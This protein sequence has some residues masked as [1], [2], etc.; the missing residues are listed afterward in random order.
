MAMRSTDPRLPVRFAM[1]ACAFFFLA[2]QAFLPLLG[3]QNDEAI[4][5]CAFWQP[6]GGYM[7]RLGHSHLPLML[8]SY[9]GTL[10]AWIYRPIFAVFPPGVWSLREPAVLFGV[11]SLW[12]FFL[13]LRRIAGARAAVI[14][15]G[16]LAVDALYLL[17]VSF[18]WGPVAL[19]HLLFVG[20]MLLLMRFYQEGSVRSL[21]W[22]FFLLG[23]AMWDK[24]LA[25]WMLSGMGVA[26]A[27]IFPKQIWRVA[28]PRRAAV[29]A[30]CFSLGALPLIV[31]DVNN[32]F[33]TFRGHRYS[34]GDIAG[35]ARMLMNTANGSALFGWLADEDWQTA[36]PH[37]PANALQKVS[38][39][40]SDWAGEPR[41][42]LL[43]YAFALALL[44]TPLARGG[45][46]RAILFVLIAMAVQWVQMAITVD[47]GGSVHHT[48]LLWPLPE[49]AIAVSFAAASRRLGRA[50]IPAAAGILAVTMAAGALQIN[51]YYRLA[52][53]NGGAQNW[54]DAIFPLSDAMKG[55]HAT[56]VYSV[57]WGILDS[58][59]L[60]D[61]GRLRQEA[62]FDA[63]PPDQGTP[64]MPRIAAAVGKPDDVFIAHCQGFEFFEGRNEKLLKVAEA[65]GFRRETI[66]VIRDS[67]GRPTYEA[68]RFAKR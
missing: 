23:L 7:V 24:A 63:V 26:C 13:L 14:G 44:L 4:F 67:F 58:L 59:R 42:N 11:A 33:D 38:S 62:I 35:K 2:G 6:R 32:R 15:C 52:W 5:E 17:T 45:D 3:I 12:L 65:A 64:D 54:T 57:D 34:T 28:T 50:A 36:S 19:Q 43:L 51:E 21:G 20:G 1:A 16:L 53:R 55:V 10:K 18:D 66:E 61:R 39:T 31:Y 48:I 37:A 40:V 29:A 22:G 27:V 68:Y 56:E 41:Q 25:V 46:L 47:A 9:L 8:M 30:L 49:M 60:L